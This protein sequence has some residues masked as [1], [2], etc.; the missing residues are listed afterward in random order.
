M[1]DYDDMRDAQP[2]SIVSYVYLGNNDGEILTALKTFSSKEIYKG[3]FI[4]DAVFS[5]RMPQ[6]VLK[7]RQSDCCCDGYLCLYNSSIFIGFGSTI[8]LHNTLFGL[9]PSS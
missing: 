5:N 4:G 2:T 3:N 1:G 9:L 8:V 6:N 7:L